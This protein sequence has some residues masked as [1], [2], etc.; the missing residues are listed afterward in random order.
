MNASTVETHRSF[1]ECADKLAARFAR[2]DQKILFYLVSDSEHL[3]RSLLSPVT[4]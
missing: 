4:R 1:F 2:P 3:V